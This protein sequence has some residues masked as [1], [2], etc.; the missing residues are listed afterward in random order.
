[1]AGRPTKRACCAR[2]SSAFRSGFEGE[3][4]ADLARCDIEYGY[5]SVAISYVIP[6]R[7]AK[8]TPDFLLLSNDILIETKGNLTREDR[9]KHLLI[10]KQYPDLDIRFVFGRSANKISKQ[11][12]TTYAKWCETHG[13]L[14]AD[15]RIPAE[16]LNEQPCEKRTLALHEARLKDA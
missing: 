9:K 16:W 2:K 1:M 7:S 8:Y 6:E 3:V 12:K 11:S 13:F 4:A 10:K 14:Y 15:K 5:E